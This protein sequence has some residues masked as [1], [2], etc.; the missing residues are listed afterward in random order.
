MNKK[1][2]CATAL[3]VTFSFSSYAQLGKLKGI[4]GKKDS[5]KTEE[6]KTDE[7]T[8][9]EP[10][11]KGGGFGAGLMNK[12]IGKIAKGAFAIGGTVGGMVGSTDDLT[13]VD[14]NVSF[15][16][17][18]HPT[19]V[20][21]I[22]QDFFNGWE[23]GG[24]GI[25]MMFSSKESFKFTKINGSVKVDGVPARD[26]TMGLYSSFTKGAD[27][28]KI[29]ITSD[30][31]QNSTFLINPPIQKVKLLAI[32]GQKENATVD[33]SKDV[34]LEFADMPEDTK[35][36]IMVQLTGTTIGIK[37]LYSV[38]FFAPKNKITIP[39]A[40]FRQM[41]AGNIGFGGCYL[42]VSRGKIGKATN[43]TGIYPDVKVGTI[44]YDG[45]FVKVVNKPIMNKGIEAEGKEGTSDYLVKKPAAI[46]SPNF[47]S[48]KTLGVMGF[49]A[50]GSTSY[51]DRK[52]KYQI[53]DGY[54]TTTKIAK[55][56]Q[57][58]NEMW[59]T[60]LDKLYKEITAILNQEFNV[61]VADLGKVTSSASYTAAKPY[62]IQEANTH[63]EFFITYKNT[64]ALSAY[65][66]I[67]DMG[68]LNSPEYQVM[69]ELGLNSL[70]KLT[71]NF[72]M[73]FEGNSAFM[74]PSLSYEILGPLVG[75][76]YPTTFLRGTVTGKNYYLSKKN[77]LETV[78]DV[79]TKALDLNGMT[80]AFR[81]AMKDI[82]AKETANGDYD[83]EWNAMNQ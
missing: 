56:P 38:G 50:K 23:P 62:D 72:Q 41:G 64:K 57:L 54:S 80:A 45:M 14:V 46:N 40:M 21:E 71:L 43:V 17:H 27:A 33:M 52:T 35:T 58:P 15:M 61:V 34:V 47:A 4:M 7:S 82:K 79:E 29:E 19:E 32:N 49:A 22:G 69:E 65:R 77:N 26:A 83:I 1:L 30:K 78:E 70:L 60:I 12:A 10:K 18:L 6:P 3:L 67:G 63:D 39:P 59:D 25:L 24:T 31:G 76:V 16:H 13:T 37:T 42:Q 68:G 48:M 5:T 20:Q 81:K 2:I 36:P 11:K 66:P 44:V 73:N 9:D 8:T 74:I 28:K 75:D 55:F 51:F 53:G